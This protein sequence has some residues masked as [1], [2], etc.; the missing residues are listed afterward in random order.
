MFRVR[1]RECVR[2][3]QRG[4]LG[5]SARMSVRVS[6]HARGCTPKQCPQPLINTPG[7]RANSNTEAMPEPRTCTTD[8]KT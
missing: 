7:Q 4:S 8:T 1:V 6:S 2:V 3:W 5:E